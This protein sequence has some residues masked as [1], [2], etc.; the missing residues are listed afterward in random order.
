[1]SDE[2]DE[3]IRTTCPRDC[4][5]SCGVIVVRRGGVAVRVR[6]DPADPVSRGTLCGKCSTGYNRE[7]L[8]PAVRLSRPLKR[9]GAKGSGRFTPVS[10]EEALAA[11]ASNLK[12]IVATGDAHTILNAHYTGTISLLAGNVPMRFFR[13]LGAREVTPDT[14]CNMAG[15]VAL[16]YLYGASADG[17]DPRTV[18]DSACVVVWGANPSASGPHAH[19]HWLGE[20]PCPVIVVDPVRTETA[21]AAD[22]HLQPFPGSDA[23]LAFALL[24]VL[25]RDGRLDRA[26]IAS[27][28]L[29]FEEL[30]PMLGPCTPAWG[31]AQT[32]V[33]VALIEHAARLYGSGPALLWLG[34]GFQRQPTGGNVVRACAMLPALTGN[35]GKAGAGFLYLNG[36]GSRRGVDEEYLGAVGNAPPEPAPLSHMDLAATLANRASARALIVWN[37]NPAG[38]SPEQARLR[39]ALAREDLFT[40]VLDLFATDTT[41][42]AD[43]VLPAASFLE[44]DDLV[45]PYFHLAVA[46]QV[47]ALEPPG[48]ALPNTE[49]F[50]R[51]AR[52]MGYADRELLE[53]DQEIIAHALQG[54]LARFAELAAGGTAWVSESPR[55]QFESL[56]FATPS[57]RIEIVCARAAS[58][59]HPRLPQPWADVRPAAGRLRLL[60]PASP[61]LLNTSFGNVEKISTRLGAAVIAVNARDAKALGLRSGDPVLVRNETGELELELLVSDDVQVGTAV[62]PKGR[63]PG[64]EATGANVN[65]LNPGQKTDMGESSA[66]HAVEVEIVP[67]RE[68]GSAR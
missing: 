42:Y 63:W 1:M 22:L 66:V 11:I 52:A 41:A 31:E 61:W 57:G 2:P 9:A 59:G 30:E 8:D 44:F 46:A 33:P 18:R 47:K 34:Q 24:H 43:F 20:A 17:F 62:S 5:D 50:R 40:V 21:R 60:T 4:Y 28:V 39:R 12:R 38:S 23:A 58:D 37:M 27:H 7:W 19:E 29:G 3:I 53:S 35:L 55:I 14:I 6:G 54:G 26:F 45:L 16:R 13:R 15:H 49:I 51:L 10:W 32:G 64:R 65:V 56:Q 67:A 36:E 68:A 48:E 25:A